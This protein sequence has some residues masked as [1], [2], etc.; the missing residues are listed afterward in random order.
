MDSIVLEGETYSPQ[1]GLEAQEQQRLVNL[2]MQK[3]GELPT[4]IQAVNEPTPPSQAQHILL[5][6]ATGI[7]GPHLLCDLLK[8]ST[9]TIHCLIRAHNNEDRLQYLLSDLERH[10]LSK[11]VDRN[12]IN[13]L[14]GNIG[15]PKLGLSDKDYAWACSHIDLIIHNASWTNHIRPYAWPHNL[16]Q[17]DL[18][19]T[20]IL[21][22]KEAL[23]LASTKKT[24]PIAFTSTLAAI[25]RC[26]LE[27]QLVE[28]LPSLNNRGEHLYTG[29]PQSKFVAEKLLHQAIIKGIPC[30]VI[31]LGQI[32]GHSETGLQFADN[33]H[34]MLELKSCIQLGAAPTWQVSRNFLAV[35]ITTKIM[36][37]LILED[38][39]PS[40]AY[41]IV[42]PKSIAW[43][44]II[45]A[46]ITHGYHIEFIDESAWLECLLNAGATNVLHPFLAGYLAGGGLK[47]TMPSMYKVFCNE[48]KF[49]KTIEALAQHYIKFPSSATLLEKYILHFKKTGFFPAPPS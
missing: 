35:D 49:G 39:T 23:V 10:D 19:E 33:D 28:E 30:K 5:I 17:S 24:K 6:G 47:S 15:K 38:S 40:A 31:R 26:D 27:N 48:I 32:T 34:M 3:D 9:A 8:H 7:I 20:N 14:P 11:H 21:S 12:R 1:P 37:T 46:L 43:E 41:N 18:R 44:D 36:T 13:I 25:N 29:Y 16:E 22:L 2:L 45:N 4:E 42:N